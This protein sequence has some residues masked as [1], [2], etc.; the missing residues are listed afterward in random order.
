MPQDVLCLNTDGV[1]E[2]DHLDRI[3]SLL[4]MKTFELFLRSK[5]FS[6]WLTSEQSSLVSDKTIISNPIVT[7]QIQGETIGNNSISNIEINDSFKRTLIDGKKD[8]MKVINSQSWLT[9]LLAVAETLPVP[10][11]MSTADLRRPGFPLIFV[12]KAFEKLTGYDRSEILGRNCKF[13][14]EPHGKGSTIYPLSGKSPEIIKLRASL[15]NAIPVKIRLTNFRK[16]G[17]PFYNKLLLKP[18]FDQ[19]G[20]YCFVIGLQFPDSEPIDGIWSNQAGT[21]EN[22]F[23]ML[24]DQIYIDDVNESI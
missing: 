20:N 17:S 24:P 22:L 18:I 4:V 5:Y 9:Q 8:I 23:K 15:A 21:N 11:S 1:G 19:F 12:N 6:A 13:L 10:F 16:D 2:R 14:Q 3:H 7:T